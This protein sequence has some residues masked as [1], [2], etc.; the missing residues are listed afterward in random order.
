MTLLAADP[1]ASVRARVAANAATRGGLWRDLS[2]DT[3]ESVRA[4]VAANAVAPVSVLHSMAGDSSEAVRR[5]L[6]AN[7]ATSDATLRVLYEAGPD[8]L[9]ALLLANPSAAPLCDQVPLN[10]PVLL[11]GGLAANPLCPGDWFTGLASSPEHQVQVALAANEACPADIVGA[12]ARFAARDARLLAV[13]HAN[14]PDE[15]LHQHLSGD[16]MELAGAA[17]RNPACPQR[18]DALLDRSPALEPWVVDNPACGAPIL[19]RCSASDELFVRASVARHAA[20][21]RDVLAV[22]GRDREEKVRYWVAANPATPVTV[23]AD[24]AADPSIAVALRVANNVAADGRVLRVLAEVGEARP[25]V[26]R[27]RSCPADVV[28]DMLNDP[29]VRVDA[30][31]GLIASPH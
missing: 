4:N 22:L 9:R 25:A 13:E 2:G 12:L 7:P 17:A 28:G 6:A 5:G 14:C 1:D 26:A 15:M 30:C 23:L 27:H 19:R 8:A 18:F 10:A 31:V 11:L 24:L 3:A 29:A 21:E 20:T 16:D